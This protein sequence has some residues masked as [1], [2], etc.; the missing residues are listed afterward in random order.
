MEKVAASVLSVAIALVG[1]ATASKDVATSY[2]SPIQ[3]SNY[4]CDQITA[5][6]ARLQVRLNQLEGRLDTAAAND[7]AIAGVAI[8]LFWPAAFALGGTKEQEAEYGRLKGEH[9]ALRQVWIQKNCTVNAATLLP[10]AAVQAPPISAAASPIQGAP[11]ANESA[12]FSVGDRLTYRLRDSYSGAD[13]GE[14]KMVISSISNG[15]VGFDDDSLVMSS[16][17]V[18]TKGNVTRPTILG[19]DTSRLNTGNRFQGTFRIV[20]A[21]VRDVTVDLTVVGVETLE[22]SGRRINAVRLDAS[23]YSSNEFIAIAGLKV[24]APFN[25]T[26]VVDPSTGIVISMKIKSQNTMY[27]TDWTLIGIVNPAET[28]AGRSS[29]S[30]TQPIPGAPVQT[31]SVTQAQSKEDKLKELK[32]LYDAGLI[33]AEV[34][35]AQQKTILGN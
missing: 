30:A 12:S 28:S 9:D 10:G 14:A 22:I 15:L 33:N 27:A 35:S 7:K 31:P 2:V 16:Q 32:R 8:L 20:A 21:R 34:Y 18:L 23:G 26:L 17:G 4:T 25:G 6:S 3:F 29:A 11:Q 24:G 5:E 1:C 13:Q 19:L